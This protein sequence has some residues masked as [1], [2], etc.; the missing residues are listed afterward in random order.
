MQN[1]TKVTEGNPIVLSV[2][3]WYRRN[4]SNPAAISL[5]MTILFGILFIYFFGKMFLPILM[6]VVIAYLLAPLVRLLKNWRFPHLLAVI[7]VFLIFLGLIT[8]AIV[9]LVPLLGREM[10]NLISEFPDS[11][12]RGQNWV[13]GLMLRYPKAFSD[14]QVQQAIVFLKQQSTMAGQVILKYSLMTIP[15]VL[16]A[17]IYF[18]LVPLLVFFFLKDGQIIFNWFNQFMPRE[19]SL[20][21]EVWSE[22]NTK[23]GAYIKGRVIEIIIVG[24]VTSIIFSLL[25]MPYSVLLG[26][27]VG[28][29]VIVPYV[30]G[31]VVTIPVVIVGLM[32]WGL[33]AHFLYLIIFYSLITLLDAYVLSPFLLAETMQLNA[34][35]IILSVI[36]FGAI[37]GFWG[38]FFAIPLL[39]LVNAI[40]KAWPRNQVSEV[41]VP[42]SLQ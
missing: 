19:R 15:G 12:S 10:S 22:V 26:S 38:V 39:T 11:F 41:Q 42:P 14:L 40:V 24:V 27:L 4:F 28:L 7:I 17:I 2:S 1:N 23:L 32:Q 8:L 6:A 16:Q 13:N 36:I 18:I 21:L 33:S 25:G 37:W 31:I 20:V 3:G 35:A 29:S 5:F 34:V 9:G 30:G